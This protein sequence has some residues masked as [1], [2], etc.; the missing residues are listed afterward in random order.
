MNRYKKYSDALEAEAKAEQHKP[1][2]SKSTSETEA[3]IAA[4]WKEQDDIRK[5]DEAL[6]REYREAKAKAKKLKIKV[7]QR[8]AIDT[9]D[10]VVSIVGE[11]GYHFL[12]HAW[13]FTKSLPKKVKVRLNAFYLKRSKKQLAGLMAFSVLLLG[14]VVWQGP[15][16]SSD[17][18]PEV[19]AVSGATSE[20]PSFALLY[21]TGKTQESL[22]N[23]TRKSPG[24]DIIHSYIDTIN[25]TG[26][27]VTMQEKPKNLDIEKLA[28]D[29]YRSGRIQIDENIIYHGLDDETGAQFLVTTKNNVLIFIKAEQPL[30]DDTW[31]GYY[32]SLQ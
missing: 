8:K 7:S 22:K 18:T 32:L 6:E 24:G 5:R 15:L 20:K 23:I 25:G 1:I 11:R 17:N 29:T 26:V 19:T 31:A 16:S 21:P 9:K 30:T 4:I 28:A 13:K 12:K 27:E 14:I 10:E 2:Q 3:N